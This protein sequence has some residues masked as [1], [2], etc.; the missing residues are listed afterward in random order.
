MKNYIMQILKVV[1]ADILITFLSMLLLSFLVYK[2]RFGDDTLRMGIVGV[3]VIS[4][5]IGGF[6]IGKIKESK[7]F[8]WG[9][10]TGLIYFVVL[11][12][13]SLIVTGE[14]FGNGSMAIKAFIASI[15]GGMAGGMLS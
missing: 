9:A 11:T 12:S 6:I 2:L 5:F 1:V 3:Y 10:V 15:L 13:V 4:N 7:K 8:I 14:L